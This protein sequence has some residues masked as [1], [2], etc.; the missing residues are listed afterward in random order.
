MPRRESAAH[1]PANW[2]R[3]QR[4]K[5][6]GT[7]DVQHDR[8]RKPTDPLIRRQ[9][10]G[11]ASQ[12][13]TRSVPAIS[14]IAPNKTSAPTTVQSRRAPD[15]RRAGRSL[16]TIVVIGPR[17]VPM[18]V[19]GT[20]ATPPHQR[21]WRQPACVGRATR[22]PETDQRHPDGRCEEP[23]E[24]L[25]QDLRALW[26]RWFRLRAT[27]QP[28]LARIPAWNIAIPKMGRRACSRSRKS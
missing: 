13:D 21:H 24:R 9:Q 22:N 23:I 19:S 8:Q 10:R 28:T 26:C 11:S 2:N 20:S 18:R 25:R 6:Q 3:S 4:N 16:G 1:A 7:H 14:G 5:D 17:R 15:L 27:L 12:L